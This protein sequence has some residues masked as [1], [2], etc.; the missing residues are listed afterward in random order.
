MRPGQESRLASPKGETY[1]PSAPRRGGASYRQAPHAGRPRVTTQ[2]VAEPPPPRLMDP[3]RHQIT[4]GPAGRQES[5]GLVVKNHVRVNSQ[6]R[7]GTTCLESPALRGRKRRSGPRLRRFGTS[8]DTEKRRRLD[9]SHRRV[10]ER[11][12]LSF[13]NI[14][15]CSLSYSGILGAVAVANSETTLPG[16]LQTTEEICEECKYGERTKGASDPL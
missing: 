6:V 7:S 1:L 14:L 8:I 15:D 13:P 11:P 10:Q 5:A 2:A 4:Q 3:G 12:A 16:S 9:S